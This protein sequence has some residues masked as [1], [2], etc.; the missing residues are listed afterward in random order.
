MVDCANFFNPFTGFESDFGECEGFGGLPCPGNP[1]ESC[2]STEGIFLNIYFNTA[3]STCPVFFRITQGTAA[4]T[5][6]S[7]R[8][9]YP[10]KFSAMILKGYPKLTFITVTLLV[11]ELYHIM[12]SIFTHHS[13][14][15]ILLLMLASMYVL[16]MALRLLGSS[17]PMNAVNI[18]FYVNMRFRVD[19][20]CHLF[21]L[22]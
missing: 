16:P 10:Y 17:M 15:E 3:Q 4:L 22:W 20:Y 7:W 9:I 14:G 21:R 6:G 18:L 13:R 19:H 5:S 12:P 8:L 11:H 2:G 1:D